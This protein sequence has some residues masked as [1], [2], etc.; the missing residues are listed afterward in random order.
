M[1][2][3]RSHCY[4]VRLRY[5]VL[6]GAI[7][8]I[9]RSGLSIYRVNSAHKDRSNKNIHFRYGVIWYEFRLYILSVQNVKHTD[10]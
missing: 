9:V 7:R 1:N 6:G 5:G 8:F 3:A 2:T 10:M 4:Q